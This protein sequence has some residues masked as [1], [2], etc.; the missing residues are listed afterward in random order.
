MN[1]DFQTLAAEPRAAEE[2]DRPDRPQSAQSSH[3]EEDL[4]YVRKVRDQLRL[5]TQGR[6]VRTYGPGDEIR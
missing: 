6:D 4:G 5:N 1:P 3:L 2:D